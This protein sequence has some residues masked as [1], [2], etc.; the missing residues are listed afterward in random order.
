MA[1]YLVTMEVS[2]YETYE[3]EC[4]SLETAL[5]CVWEGEVSPVATN[6]NEFQYVSH[7]VEK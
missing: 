4:D 7:K 1:K 3:V 6:D 2:T 5:E